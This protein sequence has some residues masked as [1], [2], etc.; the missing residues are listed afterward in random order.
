[1]SDAKTK[2]A[3]MTADVTPSDATIYNPPMRGMFVGGSGV[4]KLLAQGDSAASTWQAFPGMYI[5][6]EIKKVLAT[7]T[8]ATGLV[9]L[10]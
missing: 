2:P 4:I 7:G 10:W 6:V 9:A 1:M 5:P 8:T 3:T